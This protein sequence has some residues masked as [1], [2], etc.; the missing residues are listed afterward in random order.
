MTKTTETKLTEPASQLRL[1]GDWDVTCP[2]GDSDVTFLKSGLEPYSSWTPS[3]SSAVSST[4]LS[5]T[6]KYGY[7]IAF[8]D[9]ECPSPSTCP[10][11]CVATDSRSTGSVAISLPT[12]T[13]H[14]SAA[15]K[16]TCPF[17][18]AVAWASTPRRPR[19]CPGR[20]PP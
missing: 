20:N 14:R 18:G 1:P 6:S 5:L 2:G 4:F 17:S 8:G 9:D 16:W 7:M 13:V 12:S 11:S 10:I 19:G 15:S 3:T